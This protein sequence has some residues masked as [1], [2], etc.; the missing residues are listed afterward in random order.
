MAA[1]APQLLPDGRS[2]LFAITGGVGPQRWTQGEIVVED[3]ETG[4]RTTILPGGADPRYLPTGH[5][6]YAEENVLFAIPF[7][8]GSLAVTGAP[9]PM[10][11][12]VQRGTNQT[13]VGAPAA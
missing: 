10:V 11:E 1:D 5:L 2:L 9:I 8:S 6:V 7:D 12:S 3:L 13:T 4:N